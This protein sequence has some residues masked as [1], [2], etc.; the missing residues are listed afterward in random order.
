MNSAK[1]FRGN[2]VGQPWRILFERWSWRGK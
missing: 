2:K 1:S